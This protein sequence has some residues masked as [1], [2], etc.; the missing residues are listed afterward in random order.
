MIG[1]LIIY[2]IPFH[3][4]DAAIARILCDNFEDITM[5]KF[6][7][8]EFK[9]FKQ[10]AIMG[11][12]RKQTRRFRNGAGLCFTGMEPMKLPEIRDLPSGS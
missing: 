1:G 10:V 9:K 7:D 11:I 2:I 6:M 8:G 12:R 5:W 3:R 4:M